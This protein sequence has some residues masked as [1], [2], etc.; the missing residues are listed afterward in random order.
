MIS[1]VAAHE[2][3]TTLQQHLAVEGAREHTE[4]R[5]GDERVEQHGDPSARD[6]LR[7]EQPHRAVDGVARDRLEIEIVER[8]AGREAVAG[9]RPGT[10]VGERDRVR[11]TRRAT[12][13]RLD[14]ERVRDRRLGARVAVPGALDTTYPRVARLGRRF[15]LER[16][17]HLLVGRHG[18]ELFPPQVEVGRR[19]AVHVVPASPDVVLVRLTEGRV[20][21]RFSQRLVDHVRIERSRR[22]VALS[23]VDDHAHTDAFDACGRQRLDLAA[24]HLDVGLLRSA[25]R[26]PRPVR[27]VAPRPATRRAMSIKS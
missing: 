10:V 18:D 14:T 13:V 8:T 25:A 9:L 5:P 21:A 11:R 23:M 24:E 26:T 15:E 1:P 3:R 6:R 19:N 2:H 20:V 27:L 16:E 4:H 12:R 17:A 22:R 7:A